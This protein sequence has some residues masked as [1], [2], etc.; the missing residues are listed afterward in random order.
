MAYEQQ[1][2]EKTHLLETTAKVKQVREEVTKKLDEYRKDYD[3]MHIRALTAELQA[4]NLEMKLEETLRQL[5][6]E[7]AM[8]HSLVD[9]LANEKSQNSIRNNSI[10]FAKQNLSDIRTKLKLEFDKIQKNQKDMRIG[11]NSIMRC[12]FE[13]KTGGRSNYS[14]TKSDHLNNIHHSSYIT[15]RFLLCC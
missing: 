8:V 3:E 6:S 12:V 14:I 13:Y 9:E 10:E 2:F 1:Q 11:I 7:K 4:S 15:E 5:D